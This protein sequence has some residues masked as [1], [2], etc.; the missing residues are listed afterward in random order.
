MPQLPLRRYLDS[1]VVVVVVVVVVAAAAAVAAV[2]AV[3]VVPQW[4]DPFHA[5]EG[6][7]ECNNSKMRK[8]NKTRKTH[9]QR[10]TIE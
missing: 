9:T 3:A 8:N 7:E 1:V 5:S 2:V 6:R 4:N 10:V